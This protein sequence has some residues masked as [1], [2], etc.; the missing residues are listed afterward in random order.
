MP[1]FIYNFL[2]RKVEQGMGAKNKLVGA[3]QPRP[4]FARYLTCFLYFA[5]AYNTF[6]KYAKLVKYLPSCTDRVITNTFD[7]TERYYKSRTN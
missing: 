5:A 4:I 6:A 1:F 7:E 3:R 2:L